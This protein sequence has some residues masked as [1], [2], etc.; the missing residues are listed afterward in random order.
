LILVIVYNPGLAPREQTAAPAKEAH[1]PNVRE[2]EDDIE[3]QR[4]DGGQDKG[5]WHN[6]GRDNDP[7]SPGLERFYSKDVFVCETDG[8]PRWCSSCRIWKPDR[9]HHSSEI[10]RCVG[11]MDHYC[12]WVGGIISET[13]RSCPADPPPIRWG[14]E[15]TH[16]D[17]LQVFRPVCSL[18]HGILYCV[19]CCICT[20]PPGP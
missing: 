8:L 9:V 14:D 7:N 6:T 4:Y 19:P 5:E 12:P 20:L 15:L 2:H 10:N 1:R 18:Y 11:K 3:A 13:C 17:S 16:T